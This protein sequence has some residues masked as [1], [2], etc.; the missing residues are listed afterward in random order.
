MKWIN[1]TKEVQ[2]EIIERVK[3]IIFLI[4]IV[5]P[6]FVIFYK[7]KVCSLFSCTFCVKLHNPRIF[8]PHLPLIYQRYL[9][10]KMKTLL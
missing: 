10:K 8:S 5:F 9:E 7:A 4:Y 6:S 1:E 3:V 2:V